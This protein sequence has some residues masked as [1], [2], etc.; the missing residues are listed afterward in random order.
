MSAGRVARPAGTATAVL[1]AGALSVAAALLIPQALAADAGTFPYRVTYQGG[2]TSV[3]ADQAAAEQGIRDRYHCIERRTNPAKGGNHPGGASGTNPSYFAPAWYRVFARFT[4]NTGWNDVATATYAMAADI[5]KFDDGTG[6]VP[7]DA[8]G[9]GTAV[10]TRGGAAVKTTVA[11]AFMTG[12][13][14]AT[15]R[16]FYD[17]AAKTVDADSFGYYGNSLG[18]LSMLPMTGNLPNLYADG[19]TAATPDR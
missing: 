17:E 7:E 2:V 6:P 18:R 5:Q 9:D 19:G 3:A 10:G 14:T 8:R 16:G 4:G 11:A 1:A 13:D 12:T 15:A